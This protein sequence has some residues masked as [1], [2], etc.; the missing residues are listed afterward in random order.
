MNIKNILLM[1]TILSSSNT[2]AMSSDGK[3]PQ[4][5]F[6][7]EQV[8]NACRWSDNWGGCMGAQIMAAIKGCW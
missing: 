6:L 1:L 4:C 5:D 8:Q 3:N 2:F 7:L